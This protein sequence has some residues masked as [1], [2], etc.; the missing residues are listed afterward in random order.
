VFVVCRA[1]TGGGGGE[2]KNTALKGQLAEFRSG[3]AKDLDKL[4]RTR[5]VST[6]PTD[7]ATARGEAG[8][9]VRAAS[10]ADDGGEGADGDAFDAD[11]AGAPAAAGAAGEGE[12]KKPKAGTVKIKA[13]RK[14][15]SIARTNLHSVATNSLKAGLALRNAVQ[16][17][18][19]EF[20][21]LQPSGPSS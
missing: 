13:R 16:V 15:G 6:A 12:Q 19:V 7:G 3:S 9:E 4:M 8:G 11:A 1:P 5:V 14:M 18:P 21:L 17:S 2:Q 20:G 10:P